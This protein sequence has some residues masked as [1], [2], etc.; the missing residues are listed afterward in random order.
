MTDGRQKLR[1]L[2]LLGG[3][4]LRA[5]LSDLGGNGDDFEAATETLSASFKRKSAVRAER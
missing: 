4:G 2:L 3:S 5:M 1:L